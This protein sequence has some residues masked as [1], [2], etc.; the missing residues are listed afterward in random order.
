M[1]K[2]NPAVIAHVNMMQGI[3]KRM[4][5]NSA[6]CKQWCIVVVS[7]VLTLTAKDSEMFL[8]RLI[9][10]IM[11][12]FMDCFYLD[13]ERQTIKGFNSFLDKLSASGAVDDDVYK[14]AIGRKKDSAG[15][16]R[17]LIDLVAL[18]IWNF[19]KGISAAFLSLSIFPFYLSLALLVYLLD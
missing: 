12:C 19:V 11:F 17:C 7:A 15:G 13:L 2:D 1:T 10:V 14:V 9:P 16:K 4:A 6:S 5:S 8:L 18:K 3:I